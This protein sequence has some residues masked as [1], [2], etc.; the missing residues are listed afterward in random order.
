[1]FKQAAQKLCLFAIPHADNGY[2]PHFVRHRSL[3]AYSA[4][5]IG[6]KLML[7]LV[8]FLIYPNP[9][10]FSTITTNRIVELTNKERI[11]QGLPELKRN[12]V[13]DLTA[14]LKAEDML[15]NNYFAH[16]S[17]DGIKPW[18]WFKEAG[19]NYTF[20]GENLAMN[21]IEAEDAMQAWMKS[22][23]H[24]ENIMSKNYEDIGV[25]VVVGQL[26][27]YQTTLVVQVFGKTY[28]KGVSEAFVPEPQSVQTEQFAGPGEVTKQAVGQ[29]VK[30]ENQTHT[31]WLSKLLNFSK[32]FLLILLGFIIINLILTIIIRIEIQH[33]PI[34]LHCLL[35]IFVAL[36]MIFMKTHFIEQ[37]GRAVNII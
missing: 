16:T 31:G 18:H 5:L 8:L 26:E 2:K 29:E 19:Y 22:P 4:L 25:A 13:L 17:P 21:F 12:S 9:A 32:S 28:I 36:T 30:L 33:K 1:M 35:V 24:K 3:A 11:A 6:I 34:I 15:K 10:Q 37:I 27:G 7:I 23:S 14:K 20:A